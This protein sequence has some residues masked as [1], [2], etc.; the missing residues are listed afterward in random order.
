MNNMSDEV[1]IEVMILGYNCKEDVLDCLDSVQRLDY[2]AYSVT[3]LDNASDDGTIAAVHSSFP[4]VRVVEYDENYGFPEGYDRAIQATD[5]KYVALL[6]PDTI[7]P[8]NWLTNYAREI[9]ESGDDVAAWAGRI[10]ILDSKKVHFTGIQITPMGSG[11]EPDVWKNQDDIDDEER[12]WTAAGCG[13]NMIV[14]TVKFADIGGFDR[15]YFMYFEDVDFGWRTWI[16]G[17]KIRY[18]P[19]AQVEHRFGGVVGSQSPFESPFRAFYGT[20]NRKLT[21]LKNATMRRLIYGIPISIAYDGVFFTQA[22]LEGELSVAANVLRANL[23]LIRNLPSTMEKRANIQSKR[24]CS[25]ELLSE[26]GIF[27]SLKESVEFFLRL[28]RVV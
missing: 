16:Q 14:D 13:A 2:D 27:A 19:D 26:Y 8:P 7:V 25:E 28:R 4:E 20:R 15:D 10:N 9:Q 6:N 3:Y 18:V 22:I 21:L 5:A 12:Q 1:P 11:I 24:V 23:D 17:Y